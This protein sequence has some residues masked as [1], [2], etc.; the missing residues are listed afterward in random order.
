MLTFFSTLRYV[1]L[2]FRYVT[3]NEVFTLRDVIRYVREGR[4]DA[5][6][7]TNLTPLKKWTRPK[8]ESGK[9]YQHDTPLKIGL[10]QKFITNLTPLEK[11]DSLKSSSSRVFEGRTNN[12]FLA[13]G[14]TNNQT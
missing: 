11:M 2:T 4:E 9:I 3:S 10:S 12:I 1:T 14:R 7:I 8:I 13:G 6:M 5:L